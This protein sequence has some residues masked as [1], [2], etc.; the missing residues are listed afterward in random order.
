[1]NEVCGRKQHRLSGTR[2]LFIFTD[3]FFSFNSKIISASHLFAREVSLFIYLF[4][5]S[6]FNSKIVAALHLLAR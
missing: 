3:F 2:N 4:H 1:M 5:V 6:L